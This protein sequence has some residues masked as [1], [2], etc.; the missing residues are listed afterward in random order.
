MSTPR[1]KFPFRLPLEYTDGT[2]LE[3]L[4]DL[5]M[6]S[7][8]RVKVIGNPGNGAYEWC[9]EDEGGIRYSDCGYG[10]PEC[11]L[12]DGL[13]AWWGESV[14]IAKVTARTRA[15]TRTQL[16]TYQSPDQPSGSRDA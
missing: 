4:Y 13:A 8:S 12:R 7:G 10:I 15:K 2:H 14:D 11:A 16:R 5:E 9:I 6:D 3:V 1:P